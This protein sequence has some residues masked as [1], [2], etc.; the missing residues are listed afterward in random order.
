[1]AESVTPRDNPWLSI[2]LEDYEQHMALP[3][4]GQAQMLADELERAV[5]MHS[6]TSV[7]VI[8]CAGGNG[9]DRLAPMRVG[10]IVGIDINPAYVET[11]RRRHA[12]HIDGLELYVADIQAPVPHCAPV[13]LI[14][15]ALVLEYVDVERAMVAFRRLC[16]PKG[17]LLVVLQVA[18]PKLEAVSQSPFSSL[19]L[20]GPSMHLREEAEI[21]HCATSAGFNLETSR[22]VTLPSAKAFRVMAFRN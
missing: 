11:A 21:A 20:L 12:A 1:M 19:Q 7:A 3:Q 13:E 14:Y 5:S 18:D 10:R 22:L 2:P 17:R 4:I 9:F 15:A 6:P 8:G 16:L